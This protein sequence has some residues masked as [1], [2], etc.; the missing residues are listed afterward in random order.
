MGHVNILLKIIHQLW[1]FFDDPVD[2]I[3]TRVERNPNRE[4][5]WVSKTSDG[6]LPIYQ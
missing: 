3:K 6:D 4:K 1:M 5:E 2:K